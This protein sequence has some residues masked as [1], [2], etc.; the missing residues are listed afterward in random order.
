VENNDFLLEINDC[1][2]D[3]C[4]IHKGKNNKAFSIN[5]KSS[6]SYIRIVHKLLIIAIIKKY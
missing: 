2:G 1:S 4:V 5:F 6:E 3:T